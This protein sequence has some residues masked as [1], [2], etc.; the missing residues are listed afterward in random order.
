MSSRRRSRSL[1]IVLR[2]TSWNLHRCW[3]ALVDP[4]RRRRWPVS[5][6]VARRATGAFAIR[7]ISRPWRR[8]GVPLEPPVGALSLC[9]A[10]SALARARPPGSACSYATPLGMPESDAGSRRTSS[11]MR[12]L[13]RCRRGHSAAGDPTA[14]RACRRRDRLRLPARDRQRRDHPHRPRTTRA[15]DRGQQQ[16][17]IPRAPPAIATRQPSSRPDG[18]APATPSDADE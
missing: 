3:V 13:S 9:S 6:R 12:T 18:S 17:L 8:S 16:C 4:A 1:I 10:L 2:R 15:R 14:A 7:R 5:T 11:A